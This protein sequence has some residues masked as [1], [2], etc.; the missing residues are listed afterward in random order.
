MKR[1]FTSCLGRNAILSCFVALLWACCVEPGL[2]AGSVAAYSAS[3]SGPI[4]AVAD[5]A[6]LNIGHKFTAKHGDIRVL[7]LGV[8]DYNGD[9]LKA[10]HLVIFFSNTVN[11]ASVTV[12]AGT[13]APL[14]NGCRFA[15][16]A[17]PLVLSA[18]QYSVVVYQMNGGSASDA[19]GDISGANN[20]F[21]GGAEFTDGGSIYEFTTHTSAYPGK[22]GASLGSSASNLGSAS[23][24]YEVSSLNPSYI[25]DSAKTTYGGNGNN[26]GLNIGHTF[27]VVSN[28]VQ[29]SNLGVF[30]F[31]GD[32]L[33]AAHV[34]TLFTNSAGTYLPITGGTTTV[35][36][37]T[38]APLAKGF[39]FAALPSAL[40][41]PAGR[42]AVIAYQMNGSGSSDA[43]GEANATSFNGDGYVT[44]DGFTPYQFTTDASP[45]YPNSGGSANLACASF[46]YA[47][48]ADEAGRT[49]AFTASTS[50][51]FGVNGNNPGLNIGNV[52]TVSG[53]NILVSNLGVYDY[54]GNGLA[55]AHTVSL[56]VQ[57][58]AVY[59]P[60]T[61][62]SVEVPAGTN[63]WLVDSYRF[64]P[65]P[66]PVALPPG[67]Y[68]VIAYQMNGGANSDPYSDLTGSNNGFN[69]GTHL[70]NGGSL[71][72][73]TTS[74]SPS[75]PGTGGGNTGT[76][77]G[78]FGC[79]SL[80]Y[81]LTST[82]SVG[83]SA[84]VISPQLTYFNPGE[85]VSL[86]ANA[87]GSP[88]ISYQWYYGNPL[89]PIPGA[90]NSVLVLTN[91]RPVHRI[92]HAGD[93]A[94]SA[95]N[96]LGGPLM[97]T[98]PQQVR[99]VAISPSTPLKI[100]PLGDSITYGQGAAGGYRAPLY[101]LLA[102][103]NF[104]VKFVG[105]QK[106]NPT[107]WLPSTDHEGHSGY[108]IDQITSG[109]L[110]W[111]SAVASPDIILLLI[112]T[113]D[114][115]QQYATPSATNRLDRLIW[116]IA[117]N[118]PNAKL[119]VGN[120]VL[121]TDNS[122]Y[123]N[124]IQTGFNRFVPGIV[125]SHAA[126]G[127]RVSFVDMH[128]ALGASDLIDGLHPN[129][130]GYNKMAAAWSKA[131]LELMPPPGSTNACLLPAGTNC[132]LTYFGI[133]QCEYITERSTNLAT[134]SWLPIST[135]VAPAAGVFEVVDSFSNL[136][137]AAARSAFYRLVPQ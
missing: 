118:R 122:T 3:V 96:A 116:H 63:A 119:I 42:Y 68:A 55:S 91:L 10:P 46:D 124:Q 6:G 8:Y 53:T 61:G 101:Q 132:T 72:E 25:A 27:T 35:P 112:G 135:N 26:T 4:G 109:F 9:G 44:D 90:T 45:A 120:L 74:G 60:V 65:L 92:G 2:A 54:A 105:S 89:V 47:P 83:V 75:F 123:E 113:N 17:V 23:F 98:N 30:D 106:N 104:N 137:G 110:G 34:V 66:S 57:V 114:Y 15:P 88:P 107:S 16:L 21:N 93:Y 82:A 111:V 125:N 40:T 62:G 64:A 80:I 103:T 33:N 39:R 127:H 73:F 38:A 36:A 86:T 58:G 99:V 32:G 31:G 84:P 43:Y 48:V 59:A 49:V 7:Q 19:Y 130:S 126:L 115:G 52:F 1:R 51:P 70:F 29:I 108:R 18:G 28:A 76:T 121:R 56:F 87:F 81:S 71:Y 22:G 50:G 100:M 136:P 14:I 77:A 94:A 78:N 85:S 117:T 97:S 133:P 37:G 5:N 102:G 129:Q 13:T 24:I 79:A 131:I 67:R 134:G 12:P 41:L 20:T 11:V 69:G 95:Q 128:A